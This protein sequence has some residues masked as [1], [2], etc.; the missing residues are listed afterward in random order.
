MS[1]H[2]LRCLALSALVVGLALLAGCE[3]PPM[4]SKQQGYRGTGMV[5][6]ENPRIAAAQRAAL[7]A[8]PDAP[9]PLPAAGPTA[10]SIYQNVK[11]LGDLPVAD[12]TRHMLAITQWVAPDQGCAYCH[13][14]ANL[15][16][17]SKYTKVVARRMLQMTRHVNTDWKTHVAD[18][19]VTCYTC[20]RGHPVPQQAWYATPVPKHDVAG[21]LGNDG[22]QNK[23][24]ES[25]A[26]T[27]LPYDPL[28]TYLTDDEAIRVQGPTA[29]PTGN[30]DSIKQAEFT[31]GLMMHISKS[32]GVNCTFCHNTRSFQAWDGPPQRATAY[33]GIRMA[34]DLNRDY[35]I[36]LTA[37]LPP[38]RRGPTG[39]AGKVACATCH[40]GVNKP[41]AGLAMAKDFSGLSAPAAA[42]SAPDTAASGVVASR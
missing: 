32:L 4:Q 6:I 21:M 14:L 24:S 3:R 19:G 20:H 37:I 18:T 35:L 15:A 16:D 1:P 23:A 9:P 5:G 31:Y 33:W 34:R 30:R 42:A 17:D 2:L 13:N 26:L 25:V 12:F 28:S 11:V 39:D 27:S 8:V 22:G 29:L 38:E 10:G 7:P 40:Q 36:P 41:L